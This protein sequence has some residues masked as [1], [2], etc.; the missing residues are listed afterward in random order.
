MFDYCAIISAAAQARIKTHY[1]EPNNNM[2]KSL[3]AIFLI[4]LF[5]F[6][7]IA[8]SKKK[9]ATVKKASTTA[10]ATKASPAAVTD[11]KKPEEKMAV[12]NKECPVSGGK[13]NPQYRAE[14]NGQYVYVCCQGCV[15]EF[16]KDP[17]KVVAKMSKEEKAAIQT[18]ALCPMSKEAITSKDFWVED[19]GKKVYFCCAGCKASY[20]K[21][22]AAKK[23]GN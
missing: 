20:E 12:T 22:M 16:K 23:A 14:Y 9:T 4:T 21:K 10:K 7:A 15:E 13:V 6:A 17:E 11:E 8:D 19:S 3:I 5:A 18:N 2:R 1:K